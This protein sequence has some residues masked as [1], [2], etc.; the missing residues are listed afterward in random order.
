V[1]DAAITDHQQRVD[2]RFENAVEVLARDRRFLQHLGEHI[3]ADDDVVGRVVTAALRNST[4][5]VV[6][7]QPV[8]GPQDLLELL[9]SILA[10]RA[11]R[12]ESECPSFVTGRRV[13]PIV[14][15]ACAH[16]LQQAEQAFVFCRRGTRG[17][18]R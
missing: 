17:P 15:G 13:Q 18:A 11:Q 1:C 14:G 10:A 4:G 2:H 3:D 5:E 16:P 7:R 8:D 9:L 6:R 12:G